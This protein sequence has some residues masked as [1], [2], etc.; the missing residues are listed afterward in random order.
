MG[1]LKLFMVVHALA[2]GLPTPADEIPGDF[3]ESLEIPGVSRIATFASLPS[4][5]HDLF[6]LFSLIWR[7]STSSH[8]P[9]RCK[10][11]SRFYWRFLWSIVHHFNIS[12]CYYML[13]C[14]TKFGVFRE[15]IV[16]RATSGGRREIELNS[17][18]LSPIPGGLATLASIPG[19]SLSFSWPEMHA[20]IFYHKVF[21]P[22]IETRK[23]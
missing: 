21:Y 15:I 22:A 10:V 14:N 6:W 2:L 1:V 13:L 9:F 19:W 8:I 11:S 20:L 18:R 7:N 17:G 5:T 4:K 16:S 3:F 23:L 12:L